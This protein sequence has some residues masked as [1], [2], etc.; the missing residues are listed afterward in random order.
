MSTINRAVRKQ[1]FEQLSAFRYQMR[2]FERFPNAPRKTKASRHYST[3]CSCTSRDI[4]IETGQRLANWLNDFRRTI[5]GLS[6]LSRDVR[7]WGL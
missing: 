5:T 6:R 7:H 4:Q 1:D 3:C 2:L